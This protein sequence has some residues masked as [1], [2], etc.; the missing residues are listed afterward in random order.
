MLD[1]RA[2]S[3]GAMRPWLWRLAVFAVAAVFVAAFTPVLPA[4]AATMTVACGAQAG[5]TASDGAAQCRRVPSTPDCLGQPGHFACYSFL[6]TPIVQFLPQTDAGSWPR[7]DGAAWRVVV[8]V[9]EAPPP[10]TA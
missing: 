8:R 10:R 1:R 9:P 2:N 5:P 6:P 4:S 3:N 7:P